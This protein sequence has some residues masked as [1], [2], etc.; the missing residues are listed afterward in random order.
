MHLL[1]LIFFTASSSFGASALVS[2]S[3]IQN[4]NTYLASYDGLSQSSN[5]ASSLPSTAGNNTV[6]ISTYINDAE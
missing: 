4:K 3:S 6:C 2:L 5:G 1:E